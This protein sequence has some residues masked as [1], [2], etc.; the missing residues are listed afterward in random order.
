MASAS[1]L[2]FFGT[3]DGLK[4]KP[5]KVMRGALGAILFCAFAGTAGAQDLPGDP[6]AGSL[7]AGLQGGATMISDSELSSSGISGAGFS[8]VE[9][10]FSTGFN[11]GG[12]LGFKMKNGLRFE[13]EYTYR[14][15]DI[16]DLTGCLGGACGSASTIGASVDGDV[17]AHSVMANMFWE[18][19]FGNWL[20]SVGG[21][22]GFAVVSADMTLNGGGASVT[23]DDSDTVFAYQ[24]GAGLGYAITDNIVASIDYR[25]WATT[26]PDF[27]GTEAEVG[28]HNINV[29][30]R[31]YF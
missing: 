28:T 7:Y 8:D 26:D 12:I 10:E 18:P 23:A 1:T 4:E 17:S 29:G 15:A 31:T 21:G 22:L 30:I 13:G 25:Y 6:T 20:P 9:T 11:V 24:A 14:Q 5:M 27:G 19:R 16:D 3:P 2:P